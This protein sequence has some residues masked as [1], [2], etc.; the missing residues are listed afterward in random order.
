MLK[1][2]TDA[3]ILRVIIPV[4]LICLCFIDVSAAESTESPEKFETKQESPAAR[5][6][7]R[8]AAQTR[9]QEQRAVKQQRREAKRNAR[10][11]KREA[12][13]DDF[14]DLLFLLPAS[15]SA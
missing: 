2:L 14:D 5:K 11:Q 13:S 7:A 1:P 4:V 8:A 9:K 10:C 15:H 12:R 6:A 3:T